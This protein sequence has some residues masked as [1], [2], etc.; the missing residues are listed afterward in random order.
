MSIKNNNADEEISLLTTTGTTYIN[1]SMAEESLSIRGLKSLTTVLQISKA[2][3]AV[4]QPFAT[5]TLGAFTK[6]HAF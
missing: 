6:P 2:S 5:K 4:L 3:P 1:D